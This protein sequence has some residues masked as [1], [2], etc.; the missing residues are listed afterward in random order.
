MFPMQYKL[1]ATMETKRFS[2][3]FL[4]CYRKVLL[5]LDLGVCSEEDLGDTKVV[6]LIS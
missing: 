5:N 4:N 3:E 1:T 2:S 6:D